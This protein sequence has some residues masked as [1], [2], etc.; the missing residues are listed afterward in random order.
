MRLR[1]TWTLKASG[2]SQ[3]L[4]A[5]Q[6]RPL[7]GD[8]LVGCWMHGTQEQVDLTEAFTV[9]PRRDLEVPA[10][11]G[12][13]FGINRSPCGELAVSRRYAGQPGSASAVAPPNTRD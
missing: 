2:L 11:P 13:S 3:A 9:R 7:Y 10:S 4:P 8:V 6:R 12:L 1:T 5:A